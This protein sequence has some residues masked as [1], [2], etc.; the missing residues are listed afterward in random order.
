M[1]ND[2]QILQTQLPGSWWTP[3]WFAGS[4]ELFK[5]PFYEGSRWGYLFVKLAREVRTW[6]IMNLMKPALDG[7]V[8][9][10]DFS[11]NHSFGTGSTS[12][13]RKWSLNQ[14]PWGFQLCYKGCL[15]MLQLQY[16]KKNRLWMPQN[17]NGHGSWMSL[18]PVLT[19]SPGSPANVLLCT[20][21][22]FYHPCIGTWTNQPWKTIHFAPEIWPIGRPSHSPLPNFQPPILSGGTKSISCPP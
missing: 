20:F 7:S 9:A 11:F 2:S 13:K 1:W 6:A 17:V 4:L 15:S 21:Q 14:L 8:V 19:R 12:I 22:T 3:I 18:W 16:G 10:K 5:L